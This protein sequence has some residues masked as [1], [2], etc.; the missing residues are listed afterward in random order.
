MKLRDF[1][2][3]NLCGE[4]RHFQKL[5]FSPLAKYFFNPLTKVHVSETTIILCILE[6]TKVSDFIAVLFCTSLGEPPKFDSVIASNLS[7][8]FLNRQGDN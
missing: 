3:E 1:S 8:P 4:L 6:F 7:S 2:L 5:F